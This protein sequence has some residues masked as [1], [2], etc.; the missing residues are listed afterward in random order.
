MEFEARVDAIVAD[1]CD[2][3]ADEIAEKGMNCYQKA[4]LMNRARW[5]AR[6]RMRKEEGENE[7]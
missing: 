2:E 5:I 4:A 1:F 7:K 6:D 3:Y